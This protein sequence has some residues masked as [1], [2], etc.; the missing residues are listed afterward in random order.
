MNESRPLSIIHESY[1]FNCFTQKFIEKTL[2]MYK[3]LEECKGDD[4]KEKLQFELDKSFK[5]GYD[6][7]IIKKTE[8][9][10]A[11]SG[12]HFLAIACGDY[13]FIYRRESVIMPDSSDDE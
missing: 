1:I 3:I 4:C 11:L 9:I 2:R 12:R 13:I 7:Y 6:C 10:I 8:K 5:R